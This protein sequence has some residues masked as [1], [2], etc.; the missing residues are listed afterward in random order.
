MKI[1]A[2]LI[3]SVALIVPGA[4]AAAI[5]IDNPATVNPTTVSETGYKLQTEDSS[6]GVGNCAP[7]ESAYADCEAGT[8]QIGSAEFC[9]SASEAIFQEKRG[10]VWISLGVGQFVT[11]S[12]WGN[13][14]FGV[15]DP[16]FLEPT[17]TLDFSQT[18]TKTFRWIIDGETEAEFE[19][20]FYNPAVEALRGQGPAD[21]EF[22]AWTK[23]MANGNQIK[24][25]AKYMQPGQKVQFMVQN[26]S[27]SYE[28]YAWK[29]VESDD[30]NADGSYKDM[31]NHIYFI[32]T[33]DLE[34]GKNRVR[35]LVDGELVWGT[36]TY[37]I[38]DPLSVGVTRSTEDQEDDII[39]F[40]VK[41]IYY[42][43]SDATDRKL[44]TN[45]TILASLREGN[46]YLKDEIGREFELD[47]TLSG[48]I[49]IGFIQGGL[50]TSELESRLDSDSFSLDELLDGTAF[51]QTTD[52][53]KSY[54]LFL[55]GVRSDSYC[56][57]GQLPGQIST[58]LITDSGCRGEAHG[59]DNYYS[60]TWVHEVFHNL[61]VDH[62]NSRC[63][64]MRGGEYSS[65]NPCY[66]DQPRTIDRNREF[67]LGSDKAGVDITKLKVWK[68][69][70]INSLDATNPCLRL[71]AENGSYA[72]GLGEVTIGPGFYCWDGISAYQLQMNVGGSWTN[73]AAGQHSENPWGSLDTWECDDP[74]FPYAPSATMYVEEAFKAEFRWLVDG[75]PQDIFTIHF[76]W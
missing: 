50:S 20:N 21:G 13:N 9:Y 17:I 18:G 35:I 19:V 42:L 30:L 37:S 7:G 67:Y 59:L 11:T 57:K 22:S 76:Q 38:K 8:I 61:G 68:G 5:S 75:R 34:P 69:D 58:V 39:G 1:V 46:E 33:L 32:R 29:R 62:V 36:K 60:L 23:Q 73:V 55:E 74:F 4:A 6:E 31:Q 41:P 48:S 56:G 65:G 64:L 14:D 63:D 12:G 72:C 47:T 28:Q 15:C 24:F 51:E 66:S 54:V 70:N 49:D 26:S 52:S 2:S 3:A 53:R 40:Q 10:T 16:G 25:Y 27:G 44:D 43:P 71:D 45:G